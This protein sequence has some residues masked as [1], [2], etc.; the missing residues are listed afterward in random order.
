MCGEIQSS[1]HQLFIVI[2]LSNNSQ[3]VGHNSWI[4]LG[5]CCHVCKV[6]KFQA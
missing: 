2:L 3:R 1:Y 4:L 6:E 5:N